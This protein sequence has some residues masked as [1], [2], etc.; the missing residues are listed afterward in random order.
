MGE[1]SAGEPMKQIAICVFLLIVVVAFYGADQKDSERLKNMKE[2]T[3]PVELARLILNEGDAALTGT[4]SG[5]TLDI[6]YHIDPWALTKGTMQSQFNLQT[7]E[8][9]PDEFKQFPELQKIIIRS[10]A[11][12]RSKR[13]DESRGPILKVVFTRRNAATVHWDRIV[14]T[15]IPDIADDF[16]KHPSFA[17]GD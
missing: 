16:W 3:D 13:G 9:V 15:D 17:R 11:K 4:R 5:S 8:I 6:S 2:A 1:Q 12:F 10:D 7:S 14:S